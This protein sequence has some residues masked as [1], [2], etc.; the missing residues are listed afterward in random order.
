MPSFEECEGREA[1]ELKSANVAKNA[2]TPSCPRRGS[3]YLSVSPP[4]S[5][6]QATSGASREDRRDVAAAE[7]FVDGLDSVDV[8]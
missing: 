6:S 1:R 2:G 7:R 4:Q 3:S 5:C 8:A